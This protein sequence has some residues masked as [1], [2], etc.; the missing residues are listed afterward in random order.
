M[1]IKKLTLS[2]ASQVYDAF[3]SAQV[4]VGTTKT[5]GFY[6]YNLSEEDLGERLRVSEKDG[7]GLCLIDGREI[8]AYVIGYSFKRAGDLQ[9]SVLDSICVPQDVVY[10]DQLY[11][12]PKCMLHLVGRL[13]D[14]WTNIAYGKTQTGI[15]CAIPQEPWRNLASERFTSARGFRK[16]GVVKENGLSLGIFTKPIWQ[17]GEVVRDL[18]IEFGGRR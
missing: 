11:L 17:V 13:V 8:L 16:R 15:F 4:P 5:S 18:P 14:L 1:K 3:C 6:E 12:N 9:D 7:L 2:D 10:A